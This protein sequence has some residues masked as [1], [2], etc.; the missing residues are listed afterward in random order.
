MP[1]R[2]ERRDGLAIVTIA[3]APVNA[4][5]RAER[6]GLLEAMREI[7]ASPDLRAV[8]LTGDGRT[9]AAGADIREFD[10]EPQPP[11]L[12]EVVNAIEA[13]AV[14]WIAVING[15][16][17]GA[18]LELALACDRRI[19]AADVTLAL[20]EVKL[21]VVPG[22]GGTQRLP[23]LVGFGA[24]VTMISEGAT[25]RADEALK[26]GLVDEVADDPL[27]RALEIGARGIA[28]ERRRLSCEPR[29]EFDATISQAA[30]KRAQKK[31]R[32]EAAPLRAIE[33]VELATRADF[34][35]G[36]QAERAAFLTL[37]RSA[38]AKA[39][40]HLFFAERGA[41]TP[42]NLASVAPTDIRRCVVVGGG[43]MG[44]G[45][46][47]A[48]V[49]AGIAVSL[50]EADEAARA[51][52][53]NN[54]DKLIDDG[55]RRGSLSRDR[56]DAL[57]GL[58][59]LHT[60]YE[61][62]GGAD[63][64]IE[65]A[66]ENMNVK[67]QIF[68]KLDAVMPPHAVL[69]TNT[70][71]LDVNEIAGS[72]S[73]PA[74]VVGLHFFSPPHIMQLLEVVRADATSD[75]ALASAFA[76]AAKLK[77]LPVL[78]GVCDGF[79]GNRILVRYREI[80]DMILM[81]GGLPWEVD[82]AMVEFGYP[83]GPYEAQD[84]AGLDIAHAQRQR[85]AA[86]RNRERRYIPIGDRMVAEGRLGKK[87]GVGW[88]RYPGNGGAVVDPLLEDLIVEE[89]RFANVERRRFSKDEIRRRLLAAMINEA[90][91]ILHEGIAA[92]AGDI[93]LVTVHGYGFPR[94]RG[95]LMHFAQDYGL[96]NVVADI[97]S[98]AHDDP[99][100]WRPG[101][102]LLALAGGT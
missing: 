10:G 82:E 15:A 63:L 54:L 100:V 52:A 5:G 80:A 17:L 76:L 27:Q 89:A 34:A 53:R 39:L 56:A 97:Q 71:Y 44:A 66:Y 96:R 79:I 14:P 38:E 30:R 77:K 20:P 60:Q 36:S 16:A 83:M 59:T 91:D 13:S 18:G 68:A 57:A 78:A 88:Y 65:A 47:Y 69:A 26:L 50:I 72:I 61:A 48:L 93:D 94:W 11:H 6:E 32:N 49:R 29:P 58:L 84:L 98:F 81:D 92:S 75:V 8:V 24:A 1:V 101:S 45:I 42:G 22:A 3:N 90:A 7:S 73:R 102:G 95:G 67:K 9:F 74:S 55:V 62:A 64:A 25:Q 21:G 37:R 2:L 85:Q 35:E 12:P 23:R 31:F 43:T 19:A 70:S 99:V 40:R 87:T 4:I 86:T 28:T 46:A 51:R 41:R 33:L